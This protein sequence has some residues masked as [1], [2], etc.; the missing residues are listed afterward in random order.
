MDHSCF[1]SKGKMGQFEPVWTPE[2]GE[3]I[4]EA[5][6]ALACIGLGLCPG[7][8][9]LPRSG[10]PLPYFPMCISFR[11]AC[12]PF[13]ILSDAQKAQTLESI[14]ESQGGHSRA[15][16]GELIVL[17]SPPLAALAGEDMSQLGNTSQAS[18]PAP[19]HMLGPDR[20]RNTISEWC[21][22]SPTAYQA[23]SSAARDSLWRPSFS[24]IPIGRAVCFTD[25]FEV[26]LFKTQQL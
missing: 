19:A 22:L 21:H 23:F 7:I 2:I 3:V 8:H 11:W 18:S 14:S 24:Y 15:A 5:A 9:L 20:S 12:T 4:S 26:P 10:S 1:A 17:P 13:K 16:R 25:L 6:S